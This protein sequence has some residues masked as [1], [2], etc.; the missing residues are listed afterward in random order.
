MTR[1]RVFEP[2]MIKITHSDDSLVEALNITYSTDSEYVSNIILTPG[3]YVFITRIGES[4]VLHAPSREARIGDSFI[5]SAGEAVII[6]IHSI[7]VPS[8]DLI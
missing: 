3:H 4:D 2:V 1:E 7:F 5:V 6:G 8:C